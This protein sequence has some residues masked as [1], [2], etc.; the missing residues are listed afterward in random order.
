M[1]AGSAGG[2][3]V[4][5]TRAELTSG[6]RTRGQQRALDCAEERD[7]GSCCSCC[8]LATSRNTRGETKFVGQTSEEESWGTIHCVYLLQPLDTVSTWSTGTEGR[9]GPWLQHRGGCVRRLET[10]L[11]MRNVMRNS[12]ITLH[13]TQQQRRVRPADAV[14][15]ITN[16]LPLCASRCRIVDT[17]AHCRGLGRPLTRPPPPPTNKLFK[18]IKP[19]EI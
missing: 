13:S 12:N 10:D 16:M 14:T 17:P 5:I 19:V 4:S 1:V 15:V 18:Q 8:T 6:Q 7:A 11:E 3:S 2:R 9:S